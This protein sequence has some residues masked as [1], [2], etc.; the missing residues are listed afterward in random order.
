MSLPPDVEDA[1]AEQFPALRDRTRAQRALSSL[2]RQR[3]NVG[4]D[5]AVRAV[6]VLASGDVRRIESLCAE[7][8]ID[9]RDTLAAANARLVNRHYWFDQPLPEMGPLQD[10]R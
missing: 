9:P 8:Q 3:L 7:A 2:A 1:L 6:I 4:R 10:D 5:Q